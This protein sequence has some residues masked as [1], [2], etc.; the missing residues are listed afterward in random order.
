MMARMMKLMRLRLLLL[1]LIMNTSKV[2]SFPVDFALW[3][4]F[5]RLRDIWHRQE[6]EKLTSFQKFTLQKLEL[7]VMLCSTLCHL[8]EVVSFTNELCY[9][10]FCL[11]IEKWVNGSCFPVLL[12]RVFLA[13]LM[14][15]FR[16]RQ[17]CTFALQVV[18]KLQQF[19]SLYDYYTLLYLL[20]LPLVF[21][22]LCLTHIVFFLFEYS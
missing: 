22:L 9:L 4:A 3:L 8:V 6:R 14:I 16:F 13:A 7:K 1:P 2:Y 11:R 10:T 12:C 20:V 15:I 18:Y 21:T 5:R 17:H 19:F